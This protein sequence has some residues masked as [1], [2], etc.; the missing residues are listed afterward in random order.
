MLAASLLVN[1]KIVIHNC[2]HITDVEDMLEVLKVM[3]VKWEFTKDG[4]TLCAKD[5]KEM[6]LPANCKKI[7]GS[8]SFMGAMLSRYG[9]VKMPWPGGCDLGHRPI[10]F[11]IDGLKSLGVTC[12]FEKEYITHIKPRILKKYGIKMG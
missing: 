6:P 11:H 12:E 2:P 4:L 7:R 1:D 5:I 10:D 3:G 9:R 8:M